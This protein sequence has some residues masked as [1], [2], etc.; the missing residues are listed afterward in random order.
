MLLNIEVTFGKKKTGNTRKVDS[1]HL[2]LISLMCLSIQKGTPLQNKGARRGLR[3]NDY[4]DIFHIMVLV[5]VLLSQCL[6]C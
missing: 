2:R 5:T 3:L 1:S 4:L 6:K